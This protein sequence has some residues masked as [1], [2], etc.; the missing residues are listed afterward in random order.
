MSYRPPFFFN[1]QQLSQSQQTSPGQ[2]QSQQPPTLVQTSPS[3]AS[4][5]PPLPAVA[6]WHQPQQQT[7]YQSDIGT[8]YVYDNAN[9][10]SVSANPTAISVNP[11][12]HLSTTDSLQTTPN[13]QGQ[14]VGNVSSSVI[15]TLLPM[16]SGDISLSTPVSKSVCPNVSTSPKEEEMFYLAI[17]QSYMNRAEVK[18]LLAEGEAKKYLSPVKSELTDVP[19]Q[20][21]E[22]TVESS[23]ISTTSPILHPSVV[24]GGQGLVDG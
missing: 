9:Q 24:P 10:T 17:P 4:Y 15:S 2:Q 7:V 13:R 5:Q 6:P 8:R 20:E 14:T 18:S 12:S 1:T 23:T 22:E 3:V 16:A 19:V 21:Q 11:T